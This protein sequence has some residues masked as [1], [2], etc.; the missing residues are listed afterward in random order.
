MKQ[1]PYASGL[2]LNGIFS[3]NTFP[4]RPTE[5]CLQLPHYS[6]QIDSIIPFSSFVVLY[7]SYNFCYF[8]F[9]YLLS[10]CLFSL[11]DN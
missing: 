6:E 9:T 2:F 8:I 4:D 5:K 11:K 10:V 7:S 1:Y 3:G